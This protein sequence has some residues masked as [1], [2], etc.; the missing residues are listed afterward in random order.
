[1]C[2]NWGLLAKWRFCNSDSQWE[3]RIESDE[4]RRIC[5]SYAFLWAAV[6]MHSKG[7]SQQ[8]MNLISGLFL[9]ARN[10]QMFFLFGVFFAAGTITTIS[11]TARSPN[12]P[13]WAVSGLFELLFLF[14]FWSMGSFLS[15]IVHPRLRLSFGF[16]RFALVY[17]PVYV[18][19]FMTVLQDHLPLLFAVVLPL[20]LLAM[21]CMFYN[22]YFVSKSLVLAETGKSASFYDYAGSFFLIWFFP[23]GI[24]IV[25]PRINRLYAERDTRPLEMKTD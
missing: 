22:L 13:F 7:W 23:I 24:W 14:W 6:R 4:P 20:H 9:R 18:F 21:F 12:L 5:S 15:S 10:W 17:P 3:F 1:M 25:Q 2:I 19:A 16:F 11:A 8:D